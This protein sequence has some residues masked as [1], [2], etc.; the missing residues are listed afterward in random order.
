M[1]DRF[2]TRFYPIDE[3]ILGSNAIKEV[4]IRGTFFTHEHTMR[5]FRSEYYMSDLFERRARDIWEKDGAKDIND[6]ARDMALKILREHQA[7]LLEER[8]IKELRA[9][10][11]VIE[12]KGAK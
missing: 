2:L 7:P 4:G 8:V 11:A 10:L 12:Q 9:K 3:D 5:Y 6:R 1:F